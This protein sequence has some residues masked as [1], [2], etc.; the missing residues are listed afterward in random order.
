VCQKGAVAS[1]ADFFNSNRSQ[2][3]YHYSSPQLIHRSRGDRFPEEKNGVC[4]GWQQVLG[5]LWLR[6]PERIC[7]MG[8]RVHA[9]FVQ[10]SGRRDILLPGEAQQGVWS[11]CELRPVEV[12]AASVG[13]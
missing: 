2:D 11:G 5:C 1:L 9:R 3:L 8:V 4:H 7:W 12:A 6:T 13:V 10:L